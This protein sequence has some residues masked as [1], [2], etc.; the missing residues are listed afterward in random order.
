MHIVGLLL[1]VIV[2]A[3]VWYWRFKAVRELTDDV[4]D[5]LGRL[6]G[7]HRMSQFKK[8]AQASALTTITDPALAAAICLFALASEDDAS[9]HAGEA[10]IRDEIGRIVPAADLDE[11]IAY[12]RWAARDSVDARDVVRR[13]KPLW[14]EKLTREER[15][16]LVGMA[17]AV[18]ATGSGATHDQKLSLATLRMALGPDQNR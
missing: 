10:V 5:A 6:R 11:I 2:G 14:R 1:A 8:K 18:A 15:A 16:A 7:R 12:A 9:A 17:E 4:G 13:F 3:G